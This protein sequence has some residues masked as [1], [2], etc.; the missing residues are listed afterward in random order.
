MLLDQW[1][2]TRNIKE[3]LMNKLGGG[4]LLI[5]GIFIMLLGWL[6]Q[7][8]IVKWLIDIVGLLI[9]GGGFI[10][11]LAGLLKILQKK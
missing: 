6:I 4:S 11:V 10:A 7:S 8:A 1:I 5:L 3:P 9:I 2:I